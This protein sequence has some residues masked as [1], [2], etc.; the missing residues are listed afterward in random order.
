MKTFTTGQQVRLIRVY[1]SRCMTYRHGTWGD[2]TMLREPTKKSVVLPAGTV[3]TVASTPRLVTRCEQANAQAVLVKNAEGTW[4]IPAEL[5]EP[6][7]SDNAVS[8]ETNDK[9]SAG[10]AESRRVG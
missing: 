7:P 3:F 10:D 4:C 6:I 5:L 2:G 1:T 9:E 8:V